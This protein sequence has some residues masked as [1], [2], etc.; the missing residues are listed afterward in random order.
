MILVALLA[1]CSSAPEQLAETGDEGTS[2]PALEEETAATDEREI[3]ADR[4]N[5][6]PEDTDL[7]Q[8]VGGVA[9]DPVPTGSVVANSS[10]FRRMSGSWAT[11][12][13]ECGQPVYLISETRVE[14]PGEVCE[15]SE[16]IAAG[17]DSVTAALLCTAGDAAPQREL[18]RLSLLEEGLSVNVVGSVD[19]QATLQSCP[20]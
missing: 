9:V 18:L 6:T 10:T 20:P 4:D 3:V 12:L 13:E 1:S 2:Y 15:V 14:R 7:G 11:S 19:P 17:D 5:P 16:L 8:S